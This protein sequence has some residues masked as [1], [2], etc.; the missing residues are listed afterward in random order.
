MKKILAFVCLGLLVLGLALLGVLLW[1]NTAPA[2]NPST[3]VFSIDDG[4]TV[5]AIARRLESNGT[6]RSALFLRAIAR[7]EGTEGRFRKGHYNLPAGLGTFE[8]YQRLLQGQEKLVKVTIPEGATISRIAAIVEK[9]GICSAADFIAAANSREVLDSLGIK[10]ENAEGYLFPETYYLAAQW[11]AEN[12]V[13][14]MVRQLHRELDTIAPDWKKLDSESLR[15][16]LIVASIVQGEYIKDEEAPL[17]ASVFYNR[18]GINMA[19]ESCATVIYVITEKEGKKHP[20][21]IFYED[22]ERNSPWNTYRHPGLPPT[23]ISNP[24]RIAL[25]AAFQP[26]STDYLFFVLKAPNAGQHTFSRSLA[27]HARASEIYFKQQ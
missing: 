8:V 11:P 10:Q 27:E 4:D 17:M 21:R 26:A 16:K 23:A 13:R 7:L 12:L 22:L 15:E 25:R 18:L 1:L 5:D 20:K 3:V 6:I 19:L 9:A 14:H 24:G 2:G